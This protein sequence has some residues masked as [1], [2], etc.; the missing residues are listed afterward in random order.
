MPDMMTSAT[1]A[2]TAEMVERDA[3]NGCRFQPR[4]PGGQYESYF[5]RAN[6]P[7]RP[8]A[9]WIRYTVFSP[10]G[11]PGEAVGELWG[12][13]FDGESRRITAAKEV[14]PIESCQMSRTGLSVRI[15]TASLE[16]GYL[17]GRANSSAGT[18]QWNLRYEGSE[19]PLLLLPRS[20]YERGFPKAKAL[21]GTP[22][23]EFDGELVVNGEMVHVERWIGSQNHNWGSKHTDRYAWGQVCGFDED[24]DA[25]LE[26][27]TARLKLGPVWTPWMSPVVLIVGGETLG[28]NALPRAIRAD[29]HYDL[30][31]REWTIAT[32]SK[33]GQLAVRMSAPP[34]HFVALRYGNPPGGAKT[35][36]NSKIATCEVT[37][38][39]DGKTTR[40]TS[41]R[42][43][44]ELL[45]DH[46]LV[47][48]S[49]E[50]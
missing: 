38:V 17:A 47:D 11:R 25:F 14:F 19:P 48:V 43:A 49:P 23:A 45:E 12:I 20:F 34:E 22:N 7:R 27:A 37:L 33:L 15:G 28:W 24:P 6:H 41:H 46:E 39:R 1:G 30:R 44:F 31:R 8:L 3:W 10:K 13:Y 16:D 42:A 32:E 18:L 29:G 50:V 2:S 36:L 9:F 26:V 5:Q 40:L 35:C 4:D 21:V